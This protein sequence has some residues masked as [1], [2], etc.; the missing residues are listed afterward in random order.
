MSPSLSRRAALGLLA[1]ASAV[2]LAAPL[3]GCGFQPVY[4]PTASGKPGV[5]QRELAMVNV[6]VMPERPGQL[7]RQALQER[8]GSDAGGPLRYDLE[9]SF[10]ISG[11]GIA[12]QADTTATRIRLIGN[13]VWS[14]RSRD[15]ARTRLTG[16]SGRT[17]DG[18]NLIDQQYFAAD[19]ENEQAQRRIA[20]T[21]AD[22]VTN[23]LAIYFRERA[24]H[25]S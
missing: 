8:F 11:E 3:A 7:F 5:A 2:S 1:S 13:V 9:A 12:V 19:M 20:E 25:Q 16:G 14:L 17:L 4:M 24:A 6:P 21:L 15:A 23:Q 22:D 18:I 10:W